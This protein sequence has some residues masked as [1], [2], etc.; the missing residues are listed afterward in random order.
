ME[1]QNNPSSISFE[2]KT[3]TK[4]SQ[5]PREVQG[6]FSLDADVFIKSDDGVT[7]KFNLDYDLSF[8]ASLP[9]H[10]SLL[11]SNAQS[12]P[13]TDDN[14]QELTDEQLKEVRDKKDHSLTDKLDEIQAAIRQTLLDSI[15]DAVDPE[16]KAALKA[17]FDSEHVLYEL[18]TSIEAAEV[19]DYWNSENTSQRIVDFAMSFADE[20]SSPEFIEE[21]RAAVMEGFAQAK[22]ILGNIPGESGKLFNDTYE[23]A[24][25]K[26]DELD[27]DNKN[28][29]HDI[30]DQISH[31]SEQEAVSQSYL[32][33]PSPSAPARQLELVA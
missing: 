10:P 23:S 19:P 11:N 14:Q 21:L 27:T 18:E 30:M 32:Q 28:T 1:V 29:Q 6:Q 7:A 5:T 22:E 4:F 31:L 9:K 12:N 24:M 25:L 20:D 3:S 16:T 26:F 33:T 17:Q 2:S 13:L 8:H 15:L